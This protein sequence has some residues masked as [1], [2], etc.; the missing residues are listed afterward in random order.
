LVDLAAG[1]EAASEDS[2]VVVA[3]AAASVDLAAA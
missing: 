1:L 2:A 3:E